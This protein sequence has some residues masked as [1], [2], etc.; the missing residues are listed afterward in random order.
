MSLKD[1]VLSSIANEKLQIKKTCRHKVTDLYTKFEKLSIQEGNNLYL[2]EDMKLSEMFYLIANDLSEPPKCHCGNKVEFLKIKLGYSKT[3]SI[4][5]RSANPEYRKNLAAA[6]TEQY[7]DP[8]QKA[9]I[10]AKKIQTNMENLGVAHPMQNIDSFEKQQ[11]SCFKQRKLH[12]GL[13][14]QGFEPKCYDFLIKIYG[15]ENVVKGTDYLKDNGIVI[16]WKDNDGKQHFSYPDFFI[17]SHNMFVEVKSQYT[18]E[19]GYSKLMSCASALNELGF[20]YEIMI[21]EKNRKDKTYFVESFTSRLY[22]LH[23]IT[24]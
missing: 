2:N 12:N 16:K 10:E 19:T 9:A 3:C 13:S 17:V 22:N 7:S 14:L 21:Y 23:H 20:G 6:K 5:C 4:K 24:D 11:A 1:F 15:K 18:Y 8:V